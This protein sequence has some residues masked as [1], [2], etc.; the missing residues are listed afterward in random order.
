MQFI[1]FAVN[2]FLEDF[3]SPALELRPLFLWGSHINQVFRMDYE[4]INPSKPD[5]WNYTML[6]KQK[7][8][9][10]QIFTHT[11]LHGLN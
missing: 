1:E 3:A 11:F 7:F 8:S 2:D 6:L 9:G 5:S 4:L 10:E